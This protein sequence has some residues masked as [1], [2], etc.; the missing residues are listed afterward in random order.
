MTKDKGKVKGTKILKQNVW[1]LAPV[2][3]NNKYYLCGVVY[4]STL[5]YRNHK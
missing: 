5:K 2:Y 1:E 4:A 3:P